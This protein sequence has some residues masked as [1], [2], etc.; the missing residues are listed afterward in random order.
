MIVPG[1]AVATLGPGA[2][3]EGLRALPIKARNRCEHSARIALANFLREFS[4]IRR[5]PHDVQKIFGAL[6]NEQLAWC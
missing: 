4:R 3:K 1:A 2:L 6:T 5:R